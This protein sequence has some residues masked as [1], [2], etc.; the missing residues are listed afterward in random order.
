MDLV[1][2]WLKNLVSSLSF[3]VSEFCVNRVLLLAVQENHGMICTVKLMV[4][5]HMIYSPTLRNDGY[6]LQSLMGFRKWENH[7]MMH[8]WG[9]KEFPTYWELQIPPAWVMLIQSVGMLR[10][11]VYSLLLA[12]KFYLLFKASVFLT[13]SKY[14]RFSVQSTPTLLKVFP[15]T[16]KM[17]QKGWGCFYLL[18]SL[19]CD[20]NNFADIIIH[21]NRTWYA[22]RM[23]W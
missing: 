22:E 13:Q 11:L 18:V 23:C 7:M 10:L 12:Q 9:S 8:Y 5:Q 16:Q 20:F 14:D 6:G 1:L 2:F 19:F 3:P 21:C 15:K 17:L 4:Q